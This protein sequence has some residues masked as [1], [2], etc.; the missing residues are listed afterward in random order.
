[1]DFVALKAELTT[2][3]AGLG[4]APHITLG[5]DHRVAD[6]L[7]LPRATIQVARGL[8][9]S[10]EIVNAIDWA[11]VAVGV[12]LEPLKAILSAGQVDTGNVRV[13]AAFQAL[14]PVGSGTRSRIV[15]LATR[16]GSRV[17]QLFGV[18]QSVVHADVAWALRGI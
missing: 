18:T 12:S 6:L 9:P 7:N 14:F 10:H 17:E 3:P 2:D 13:R 5:S 8:I 15:A 4:Y 16:N 11:D 1:M